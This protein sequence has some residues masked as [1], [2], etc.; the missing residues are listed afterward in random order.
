MS[1]RAWMEHAACARVPVDL[2]H[3]EP[4]D[5]ETLARARAVCSA[6]PVR[7]LCGEWAV[8]RREPHGVWGG[9]T[10]PERRTLVR[11]RAVLP[12]TGEALAGDGGR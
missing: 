10:E 6:C 1:D 5:V 3:P 11:R 2:W 8:V 12:R 7:A 9:L 4:G